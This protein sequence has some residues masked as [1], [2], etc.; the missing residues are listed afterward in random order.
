MTA[1]RRIRFGLGIAALAAMAVAIRLLPVERWAEWLI[2]KVHGA[3]AWGV[4]AF[5]TAYVIAPLLLIPGSLLTLG[6]GFLYGRLCGTV[7]VS[8]ASVLAAAIAFLLGRTALRQR[9][10]RRIASDARLRA[11]DAA[12]GAR[13]FR[14][15][16]LLRLSPVVPFSLL[17]YALGA[18]RVGFWTYVVAS[19][20]GML[21]GT[22][23][24]VSLGA[25][26]TSAA[27]LR[28]EHAGFL[29]LILGLAA[30]AAAVIVLTL[31]ARRALRDTLRQPEAAA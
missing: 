3:G 26:A 5:A 8:P 4:A 1:R 11:I 13:G 30:T 31:I 19:L 15:V 24:Y 14:V 9:V 12:V 17:S 7:L 20:V 22:F 18:T 25:A 6:A 2:A 23:L 27:Q 16:L 21:P 29:P 28:G 10:E